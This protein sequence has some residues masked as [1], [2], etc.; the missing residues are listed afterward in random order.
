MKIKFQMESNFYFVISF[1]CGLQS[2]CTKVTSVLTKNF[3]RQYIL[4]LCQVGLLQE[5]KIKVLC[6][7][8]MDF[9]LINKLSV[10][11]SELL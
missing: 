10:F 11:Q 5:F 9:R 2:Q 4:I 6:W 3:L 8:D 1:K 7:Q